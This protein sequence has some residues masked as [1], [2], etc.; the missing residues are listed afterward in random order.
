MYLIYKIGGILL[1]TKFI[2]KKGDFIMNKETIAIFNMR[3]ANFYMEHG[4]RPVKIGFNSNNNKYFLL[5][6][7]GETREVYGL[8]MDECHRYHES[9]NK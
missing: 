1:L 9:K 6:I 5:F 4:V 7:K 8:W 3:Q 2:F